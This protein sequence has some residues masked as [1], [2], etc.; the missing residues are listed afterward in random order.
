MNLT[1]A[2]AD[3]LAKAREAIE[4]FKKLD[5]PYARLYTS[6]NSR[7]RKVR[8][9]F[10]ATPSFTAALACRL[11]DFGFVDYRPARIYRTSVV[12]YF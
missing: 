6:W 1:H 3:Q 2:P 11:R 12:G 9:K 4:Q 7:T 8:V 10:Y 5:V